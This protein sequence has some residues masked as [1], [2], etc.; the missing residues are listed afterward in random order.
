MDLARSHTSAEPSPLRIE[1]ITSLDGVMALEA[2]WRELESQVQDRMVFGTFDH[3]AVWYECHAG[4]YG[5]PLVGTAWRGGDLVGLVPLVY[6]RAT[7]RG[8]PVRRIGSAGLDGET[9]EILFPPWEEMALR[10]LFESLFR[11]G[12]FDVIDLF[13]IT[14]DSPRE[15][16]IM[17][18]AGSKRRSRSVSYRYATID[19]FRGYDAY[20]ETLSAKLRGNLRR[21]ERRALALG[22]MEVDRLHEPADPATV[23]RAISRVIE[24]AE[25]SWKAAAGEA[26]RANYRRFY[27]SLA[28]RFNRRGMLD[29]SILTVGG[30]DAAF[31]IGLRENGVYYDVTVSYDEAF[32]GI[33]PGTLLMQEVAKRVAGEGVRLIVSHGDREY[34]RYWASAWVDQAHLFLFAGSPLAR[35][36]EV[37]YFSIPAGAGRPQAAPI[38]APTASKTTAAPR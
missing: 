36:S 19:L 33:S 14:P 29:V 3:M 30:K 26:M 27:R 5:S 1:W 4:V 6:R 2:D 17:A 9:G 18:A 7:L 31:I 10:E 24:I 13:G 32:A 28:E 11:R 15:A 35:L 8:V 20:V 34:K 23:E 25:R 21:R 38:E 16:A 12:G 37:A 22:A